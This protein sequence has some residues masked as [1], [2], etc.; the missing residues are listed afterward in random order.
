[1]ENVNNVEEGKKMRCFFLPFSML[2]LRKL[3]IKNIEK[4]AVHIKNVLRLLL[5]CVQQKVKRVFTA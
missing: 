5:L 4:A 3:C 2:I 1:M